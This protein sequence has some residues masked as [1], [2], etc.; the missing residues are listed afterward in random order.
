MATMKDGQWWDKSWNPV[1]GCT[2]VSDGCRFCYA[3]RMACR[4]A[5]IECANIGFVTSKTPKRQRRYIDVVKM[6]HDPKIEK[7]YFKGWNGKIFCDEKSLDFPLHWRKPRRIFVNS[8]S[9]TFHPKVPFEFILKLLAVI[10]LCPQHTFQ[11]LTKR[12]DKMGAIFANIQAEDIIHWARKIARGKG[13]KLMND[14][15]VVSWPLH[16]LW[17]GVTVCTPEEKPKIDI[18]RQIPAAV[19]FISFEP[20]LADM[21]DIDLE[22]I[23][24]CIVGGESGP[25]ARPV[26]PDWARG[27]RDQCIAAGVPFFF[28]QWGEYTNDGP[29]LVIENDVVFL[30]DGTLMDVKDVMKD[31]RKYYDSPTDCVWMKRIGKKKAGSLLDGKEWKQYPKETK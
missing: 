25:N 14:A 30:K 2:K 12:V 13:G 28:K 8:M 7:T 17:A 26:H 11:I 22:G 6:W 24:W 1:V 9:D 21:G 10:H 15:A 19:R 5:A 29:G 4:L 20:L 18:L 31:W 23:S 3:E 16:N 27:I